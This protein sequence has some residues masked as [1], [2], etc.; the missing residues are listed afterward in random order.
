MNQKKILLLIFCAVIFSR[1]TE[2]PDS[3]RLGGWDYDWMLQVRSDIRA[4]D[5]TFLPALEQL[6]EAADQAL[7]GGVYSVTYKPMV[8][9]GGTINDYMSMG[10]FWWPDP[11]QPDGL[12]YMRR[13]GEVNPERNELDSPQ[14]GGMTNGVRALSLAWFFTGK[15]EYA[16]KAAELLRVFF[17]DP[18]TLMNPHL[19]YGQAIPGRTDGR[20]I[21]IIDARQFHTLV[22]AITLLE[23]SGTLNYDD[24]YKLREWFEE[25]FIWLTESKFGQDEDNYFNN[26]SVAYDVQACGIAYFIGNDQYVANKVSELPQRRMDEM[27][28]ADGRQPEELIRTRA[29]SY[30]VS[31]LRNFFDTADKGLRVGVNVFDHVTPEGGSLTK[32]MEFL[33][34]YIGREESWPYEQIH[35]WESTENSLGLLIRR[36]AVIFE[37]DRYKSLWNDKF[38][39]RV[40]T[41][42]S[43]LVISGP[44]R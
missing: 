10:P 38:Y 35:G 24:K 28:E 43:L 29:Y 21:G 5:A 14:L 39:E 16:E 26:H 15:N 44:E 1:C 9:P 3:L 42:W 11:D 25:Y 40:N 31:N 13:D 27:I 6:I 18:E 30:S 32:A 23:T 22:D 12:P 37:N 36:A 34:D 2:E 20:F 7:E 17:I 8:P 41:N 33:I 4:G 19:Q